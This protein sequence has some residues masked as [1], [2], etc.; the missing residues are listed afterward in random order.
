LNNPYRDVIAEL[1]SKQYQKERKER[2]E[3]IGGTWTS[4]KD[5]DKVSSNTTSSSVVGKYL[6]KG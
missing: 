4:F 6:K 1:L 3:S 2:E 5:K